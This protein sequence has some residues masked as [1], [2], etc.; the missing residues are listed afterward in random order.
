MRSVRP[1]DP[2]DAAYFPEFAE[3]GIDPELV[4]PPAFT[5]LSGWVPVAC[6]G[7]LVTAPGIGEAWM[8]TRQP[9]NGSGLWIARLVRDFVEDMFTEGRFVRIEATAAQ[10]RP[11]RMRF[12]EFLGMH[13]ERPLLNYGRDGHHSWL[14]AR[15]A[16]VP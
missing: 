10:D 4:P 6:A 9:L 1:F 3:L 11:D 15:I 8:M 7:I 16:D 14:Y 13:R 5:A 2:G 12:L